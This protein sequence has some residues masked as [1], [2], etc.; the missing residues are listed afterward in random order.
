[1]G[2]YLAKKGVGLL[3]IPE[4]LKYV[5][6]L[7]DREISQVN[8]IR[9]KRG[10]KGS[11][12]KGSPGYFTVPFLDRC[13]YDEKVWAIVDDIRDAW[14]IAGRF[15]A[16]RKYP[17]PSSYNIVYSKK[18]LYVE[19][20]KR[21]EH[22]I[23]KKDYGFDEVLSRRDKKDLTEQYKSQFDDSRP[24]VSLNHFLYNKEIQGH[25]LV[26]LGNPIRQN[27]WYEE[28][29]LEE[30]R[31]FR[32]FIEGMKGDFRPGR[33]GTPQLIDDCLEVITLMETIIV[34]GNTN[35]PLSPDNLFRREW[36]Q[37]KRSVRRRIDDILRENI[38]RFDRH[39]DIPTSIL[40]SMSLFLSSRRNVIVSKDGMVLTALFMSNK[41]MKGESTVITWFDSAYKS[42]RVDVAQLRIFTGINQVRLFSVG[43]DRSKPFQWVLKMGGSP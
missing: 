42:K 1:M 40:K 26:V 33:Y 13:S 8:L 16:G 4:Y 18:E 12:K 5:H 43:Y 25:H 39:K 34:T 32:K 7:L 37:F 30:I 20:Y 28:V 15:R 9:F 11:L 19:K 17:S 27:P 24:K 2:G 29:S 3:T 36:G 31:E 22:L 14:N 6:S 41:E 23:E 35:L 21:G 38:Y 10:M